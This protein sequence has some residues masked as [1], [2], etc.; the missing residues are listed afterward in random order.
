MNEN[1]TINRQTFATL[2][3]NMEDMLPL[4]IEAF[5][6]DGCT[7]LQ[8]IEKGINTLDVGVIS[9]ATH[10]MKSSAKNIGA[11]RLAEY[12]LQIEESLR[13]QQNSLDQNHLHILHKLACA[14]MTNVKTL[15]SIETC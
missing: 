15:L 3:D 4:L 1:N 2:K 8:E 10:T 6:E 11:E 12:C 13:E 14:E 5:L 9:T 7:L